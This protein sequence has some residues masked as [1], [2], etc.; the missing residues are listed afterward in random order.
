MKK[1]RINGMLA[2]VLAIIWTVGAI[3]TGVYAINK[4]PAIEAAVH[5]Y[6][7]NVETRPISISNFTKIDGSSAYNIN[8]KPGKEYSVSITGHAKD[9]DQSKISV[10]NG[11]LILDQKSRFCFFCFDQEITVD[12]QIPSLS[13][14]EGSGAV[15]YSIGK[16]SNQDFDIKLSGAS[17]ATIENLVIRNHTT[18]KLSG[19]SSAIILGS[20]KSLNLDLSGASRFKSYDFLIEDAIVEASGASQICHSDWDRDSIFRF[21]NHRIPHSGVLSRCYAESTAESVVFDSNLY[22]LPQLPA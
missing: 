1:P 15:S 16:F 20:T 13:G 3:G 2:A 6:Q 7:G 11:T 21:C 4:G 19:A 5:Q 14:I 8:V 18:I 22:A 17:K 9:L 12:V 10:E